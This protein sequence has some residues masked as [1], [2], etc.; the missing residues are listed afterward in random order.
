MKKIINHIQPFP[1]FFY[2]KI[3]NFQKLEDEISKVI[4]SISKVFNFHSTFNFFKNILYDSKYSALEIEISLIMI[5]NIAEYISDSPEI[6]KLIDDLLTFKDNSKQNFYAVK[7]IGRF[8]KWIAVH[9]ESMLNILNFL[10]EAL[11]SQ[12]SVADSAAKSFRII[13]ESCEKSILKFSETFFNIFVNLKKFNLSSTGELD[14]IKA[15]CVIV[16][17]LEG[18]HQKNILREICKIQLIRIYAGTQ[19][20]SIKFLHQL[21]E[22]FFKISS[23]EAARIFMEFWPSLSEM[24]LHCQDCEILEKIVECFKCA[25]ESYGIELFP[26]LED[27]IEKMLC[28]KNS[29]AF[30]VFPSILKVFSKIF[31]LL[32][33]THPQ[34]LLVIFEAVSTVFFQ[35]LIFHDEISHSAFEKFFILAN[36]FALKFP[37]EFAQLPN[38]IPTIELAI[39]CCGLNSPDS[40]ALEFLKNLMTIKKCNFERY[41]YDIMN[42][43][44]ER[45]IN[46]LMMASIFTYTDISKLNFVADIFDAMKIASHG[47]FSELLRNAIL[48]FPNGG[49]GNLKAVSFS[50][51]EGFFNV[52]TR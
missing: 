29:K 15:I 16:K 8:G 52:I 42:L 34:V 50:N 41:Q 33:E 45:I 9:P 14:F 37:V 49:S 38:I 12:Q 13:C 35:M 10:G 22:I 46:T 7:I 48:N 4:E 18:D 51:L 39:L 36:Q 23:K 40:S 2:N 19:S 6:S 31:N 30:Q 11:N 1:I 43:Y 20:D 5:Y 21:T 17:N 47:S 24:F 25:I 28:M 32:Q 3:S 44:G 26:I 27:I